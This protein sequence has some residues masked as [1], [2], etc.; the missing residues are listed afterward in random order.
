MTKLEKA[1][2]QMQQQILEHNQERSDWW[3]RQTDMDL[4]ELRWEQ[5]K[6]SQTSSDSQNH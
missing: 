3:Q 1:I 2:Q 5:E 6:C 4:R